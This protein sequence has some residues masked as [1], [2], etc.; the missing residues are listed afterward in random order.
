MVSKNEK[1]KLDE[2]VYI[3]GRRYKRII[4]MLLAKVFL[5]NFFK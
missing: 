1:K 3:L 2:R 4:M 5:L